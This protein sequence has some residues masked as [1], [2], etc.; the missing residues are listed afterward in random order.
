MSPPN[1]EATTIISVCLV[2][3]TI[4]I[5]VQV[6]TY[7][8]VHD[9]E[10]FLVVCTPNHE[11]LSALSFVCVTVTY[12]GG[13]ASSHNPPGTWPVRYCQFLPHQSKIIS[14]APIRVRP[15]A[16]ALPFERV[17]KK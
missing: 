15:K 10:A 12:I 9:G 8:G 4:E 14:R 1:D 6:Y 16:Y 13:V 11:E 2:G 7:D 3:P 17:Y 5:G